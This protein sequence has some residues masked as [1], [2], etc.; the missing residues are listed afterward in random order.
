MA[1]SLKVDDL[2][3]IKPFDPHG[4]P[5]NGGRRW[6]RWTKSFC[7]YADSKGLI[8]ADSAANKA[9]RRV[10]L[11][12]SAGKDVQE[13]FEPLADTSAAAD[14]AKA[15]KALNDCFIPKVNSTYQNH[16]FR[17]MEQQD[18]ESVAQFVTRL[19]Q[20]VKDSEVINP[21]IR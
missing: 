12:H 16:V 14:Y 4:D 13:I 10:L 20:L 2:S 18:G 17:G 15:E 1:A 5:S 19:K 11:L 9:Q 6:R 21:I 7:L 3:S 8:Q